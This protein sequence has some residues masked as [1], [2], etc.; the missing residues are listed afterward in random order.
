MTLPAAVCVLGPTASGK[1]GLCLSLFSPERHVIINADSQQ[2]YR[3]LPVGTAQ[4][5]DAEQAALP[6]LL[7]GFASSGSRM[8]A[9]EFG[10]LVMS[11]ILRINGEGKIPVLVGGSGLYIRTILYGLDELPGSD[12]ALR[13]RLAGEESRLG[14]ASLHA[15][16]AAVDPD[17]A[18]VVSPND[19][20]RIFRGLEVF[21][22]SGL[23]LG[24]LRKAEKKPRV[25]ATVIGLDVPRAVLYER[26]NAR[27]SAML[28]AG[29][30]G[31]TRAVM[32]SGFRDWLY[33][34]PAIGY[35]HIVD[36]LEGRTSREAMEDL[37]RRDT[38]RYA[39]RQMTWFRKMKEIL[40]HPWGGP[41]DAAAVAGTLGSRGL[42]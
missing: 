5:S 3:D 11:E 12:P 37:I 20:V 42:L 24:S 39:K 32:D 10:G 26:I 19:R 1:T 16:L 21:E 9:G 15:R 36:H 27:T 14:L 34:L 23:R 7:Y 25:D 17:Y 13:S 18:S 35:G 4:P 31:E 41:G 28:D 22:L 8:S 40:W 29:W 38:R 30:I 2:V 33:A 6:H